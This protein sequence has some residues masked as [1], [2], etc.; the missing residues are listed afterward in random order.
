[1]H[2]LILGLVDGDPGEIGRTRAAVD[3]EADLLTNFEGERLVEGT[4]VGTVTRTPDVPVVGEN[5]IYTEREEQSERVLTEFVADLDS[6]TPYVAVDS[7]DGEFLWDWFELD[8]SVTIERAHLD[9]DGIADR[10]RDLDRAEVWQVGW[11][12][13]GG[14]S[15][16]V[17]YHQDAR[18]GSDLGG[19]TQLGFQAEWAGGYF[20]GTLA[21][22]GYIAIFSDRTTEQVAAWVREEILP[23]AGFPEDEQATLDEDADDAG[24]A[25][26][27][28]SEDA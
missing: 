9:V 6:V 28:G 22:S 15:V 23:H 17:N 13:R 1:M 14:E 5:V 7:S 19:L 20:E 18:L 2:R 27:G 12:R 3:I 26:D 4:A 16:G 11:R 10:L 25:A 8:W 21:E 24:L